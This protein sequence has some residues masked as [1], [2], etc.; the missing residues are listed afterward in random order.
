MGFTLPPVVLISESLQL[1]LKL[2]LPLPAGRAEG[3]QQERQ[4]EAEILTP[5]LV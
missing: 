1:L 2:M 5:L 4:A 3:G